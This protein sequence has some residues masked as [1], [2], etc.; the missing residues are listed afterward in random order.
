MIKNLQDLRAE[1]REDFLATF[2]CIDSSC[3]QNGC[4]PH[5]ISDNEWEAQQCQY[6]WEIRFPA[7][8]KLNTFIDS[9]LDR[10]EE[11]KKQALIDI[12]RETA[13]EI[14]AR[15]KAMQERYPEFCLDVFYDSDMDFMFIKTTEYER[16][17][18]S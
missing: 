3:D 8:D 17:K 7:A 5:Q 13:E 1:A 9:V 12:R 16:I 6:C 4:V 11:D 2:K 10:A 14:S 18:P 15:F